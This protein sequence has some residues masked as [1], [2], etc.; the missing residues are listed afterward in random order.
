MK[1]KHEIFYNIEK[2]RPVRDYEVNEY[3]YAI[4]RTGT[5]YVS[6]NLRVVA[7]ENSKVD[8]SHNAKIIDRGDKDG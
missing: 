4:I 1:T 2:T 3:G 7:D 8:T 5:W 6:G